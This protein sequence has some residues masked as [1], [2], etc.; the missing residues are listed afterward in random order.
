MSDVTVTPGELEL[1]CDSLFAAHARREKPARDMSALFLGGPGVGKSQIPAESAAGLSMPYLLDHA[2]IR[3]PEDFAGLPFRMQGV[4]AAEF[5]PFGHMLEWCSA[6]EPTI[7]CIEEVG[8]ASTSTQAALMQVVEGRKVGQH[9]ISDNV[10]FIFTSNRAQDNAGAGNILSTLQSR[11]ATTLEVVPDVRSFLVWGARKGGIRQE[12][13]AYL[14]VNPNSLYAFNPQVDR[15]KPFPCPRA[16]AKAS[17]L[18][19]LHLPEAIERK[20]IGGAVGGP[21]GEEFMA[22][23]SIFKSGKVPSVPRILSDPDSVKPPDMSKRDGLSIGYAISGA[24]SAQADESNVGNAIAWM[25]KLPQEF[26]VTFLTLLI[27]RQPEM[28][29]H[30]SVIAYKAANPDVFSE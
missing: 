10:L 24:L 21:V 13:L 7:V 16:W 29:N 1:F 19:D 5:L 17:T 8:Q 26:M 2:P 14:T 28:V 20:A 11:C 18:L 3:L 6:Q 12:I 15:F 27:S 4:S 9:E 22:F 30:V 23:T 25:G